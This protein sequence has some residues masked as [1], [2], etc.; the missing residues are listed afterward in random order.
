MRSLD[1]VIQEREKHEPDSAEYHVYSCFLA[2]PSQI[3]PNADNLRTLN[4]SN[5]NDYRTFRNGVDYDFRW[6]RDRGLFPREKLVKIYDHGWKLF[7]G[8]S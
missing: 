7:N 6:L 5:D 2:Q 1:L 4:F 8:Q 3:G